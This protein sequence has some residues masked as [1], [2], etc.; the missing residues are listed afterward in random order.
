[1]RAPRAASA[2]NQDDVA[3]LQTAQAVLLR[4]MDY[5]HVDS[6]SK[7]DNADSE[8]Q[9]TSIQ[10]SPSVVLVDSWETRRPSQRSELLSGPHEDMVCFSHWADICMD[11]A[12]SLVEKLL[13]PEQ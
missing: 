10:S 5:S 3:H 1:M 13:A 6:G 2:S 12:E 9:G 7:N 4:S 11:G 8:A